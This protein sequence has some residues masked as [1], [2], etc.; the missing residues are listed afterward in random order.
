M[1]ICFRIAEVAVGVENCYRYGRDCKSE[2]LSREYAL[3]YAR[4]ADARVWLDENGIIG[5][6]GAIPYVADA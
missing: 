1:I 5:M 3:E 2:V 4:S 6:L